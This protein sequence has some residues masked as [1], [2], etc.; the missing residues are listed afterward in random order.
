MKTKLLSTL[1]VLLLTFYSTTAQEK[2]L[3]GVKKLYEVE[4]K[5]TKD[6]VG[7]DSAKIILPNK[8]LNLLFADKIGTSFGGSND[9]SLQ[10]YNATLN[11]EDNSF[12]LTINFDTRGKDKKTSKLAWIL[13]GGVKIKSDDGFANFTNSDGEFLNEN[14]ELSFKGT[15]ICNGNFNYDKLIKE[16]KKI[17]DRKKLIEER[18]KI[19]FKKYKKKED[20]Y[21]TGDLDNE[22]TL[23][24]SINSSD[25]YELESIENIIKKK[26]KKLYVE[27]LEEEVKNIESEKLYRFYSTKWWSFEAKLPLGNVS[28]NI[29]EDYANALEEKEFYAFEANASFNYMRVYSTDI[30]I[31]L[32]ALGTV[33]NNNTIIANN[34]S[35]KTF[36]DQ[37]AAAGNYL[38]TT[39][40]KKGYLTNYD[41]FGTASLLIE[42]S[43]FFLKNTIG[44]SPAIEFNAGKY[45]KVNWKLGIPVSLKDKEGK[46][47]VNFEI[48]WKEVGTLTSANHF[49][50]ISTSFLF[51]DLIN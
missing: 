16:D 36:E 37:T 29:T 26:K 45:N 10:K 19:L 32:K 30:S 46:P 28:Y 11:T 12:E 17:R 2:K 1:L 18:R 14:M 48:Q 20:E 33:K 15:Y 25:D 39:D 13:S 9:L 47:K 51:G 44:F 35:V 21:N 5:E 24:K 38:V 43:V 34:V 31:F 23:R 4:L 7:K 8:S 41:E 3:E 22:N 49:I 40:T 50:G 6:I 27:L 42:P